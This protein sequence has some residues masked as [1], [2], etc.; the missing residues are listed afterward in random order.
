M[1]KER[2][3]EDAPRL[4]AAAAAGQERG[5]QLLQQ[6]NGQDKSIGAAGDTA[7]I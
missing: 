1:L 2:F 5:Q 6:R 7:R 4:I 3:H